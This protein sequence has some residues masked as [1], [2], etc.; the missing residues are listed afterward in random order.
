MLGLI[1]FHQFP[2]PL[3]AKHWKEIKKILVLQI[4]HNLLT[5]NCIFPFPTS[6]SNFLMSL[7]DFLEE[8]DG[9]GI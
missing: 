1:D 4:D 9:S 6:L 3:P 8:K 5:S 7:W 2:I